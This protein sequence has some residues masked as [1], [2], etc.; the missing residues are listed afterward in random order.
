MI[1]HTMKWGGASLLLLVGALLAGGARSQSSQ[2]AGQTANQPARASTLQDLNEARAAFEKGQAFEKKQDWQAAFDAYKEATSRAPGKLEYLQRRELARSRLVQLRVDE[3]ERDAAA[4][5]IE[6]ARQQMR[7]ASRL[8]PD[9]SI[10]HERIKELRRMAPDIPLEEPMKLAKEILLQPA[11]GKF[12]FHLRSD[13]R[14]A[15]QE[16]A[17]RFGLSVSFDPDLRSR[18]VR[19][20]ADDLDF[21]SVT[22]VLEYE[23]GTFHTATTPKLFFVADDTL[24]AHRQYDAKVVRTISLP[25]SSTPDEMTE[26]LR[27]VREM[28]SLPQVDLDSASRT[29]TLRGTPR[30]VELAANIVQSIEQPPGELVLEFEILELDRNAASSIG[31]VPPQ[32]AT[33]YSLSSMEIREAQT[34]VNGL[35]A[36]LQQIFGQPSSLAGSSTGQIGNLLNAGQIGIGAL[37]PPLFAFG[38]G[39][40]TFLATLSGAAANFS[41]MLSVVRTG[42]RVLLRAQD[43]NPAT[44]FVGDRIPVP[45]NDYSSSLGTTIPGIS[46]SNFPTVDYSTGQGPEGIATGDFN[47]DGVPDLATANHT[48]NTVSV[49]LGNGDGT[50][51]TNVDY[52][53]GMGPIAVATGDFNG[54]G[55]TDLAVVNQTDNTVSI[56]LG[57]GDGTFLPKTDYPTGTSPTSI[58]VADFNGDG[59]LDLAITN[60][61]ANTVSILLGNGDGTFKPK[62]DYITA[63]GPVSVATG[64]FN[65]DGFP[66]LAIADFT[67]NA[68]SVFLGNGDGTFG[69]RADFLT[70]NGPTA[71]ASAD[72]NAD[73][74]PDLAVANGT[75]NTVSIL[76]GTGTGAFGLQTA[77]Q[78]DVDP[79]AITVDDYNIDGLPDIVT[80][81]RTAN[82]VA[83][84]LNTGGGTFSPFLP[85][86]VSSTPEG[87][88]SADFNGDGSP[89]AATANA[90]AN[91]VTII[92]NNTTFAGGAQPA[93]TAAGASPLS[94]YPG[95]TYE[96]VGLKIKATPRLHGD[97]EVSLQLK[98]E[99]KSLASKSVNGI[100]V[101]ANRSIEQTVRVKESQTS[102]LAG[103][104]DDQST[105]TLTGWPYISNIPGL[106]RF[107]SN[108]AKT[109]QDT[110]L[111]IV[112]TP[113]L[114]REAP[115][116]TRMLYAGHGATGPGGFGLFGR[117]LTPPFGPRPGGIIPPR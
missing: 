45:L 36:V 75:D 115:R 21:E 70:G 110:E 19:L 105:R 104:L 99:M 108:T 39:A 4:G 5:K 117:P 20:D 48:A 22:R 26:T 11:A 79:V 89:D 63:L 69:K 9:D 92:L 93:G 77:F 87:V 32:S 91:T 103:I 71:V 114:V 40:T 94:A 90:G 28:L 13:T 10:I 101:I 51:A 37:I 30:Q 74:I 52:P 111:M 50:F 31:I 86:P 61:T 23:T 84:L 3:A 83:V 14:S 102:I 59:F 66:D 65:S 88:V 47:G 98:I 55:F 76:L 112:V 38:G 57:A 16:V 73:G 12:S 82:D 56:F 64:D 96:D 6:D 41:N 72:F 107:L 85:L 68:V 95:V 106:G 49:L 43:G 2:T 116:Q 67:S 34:G 60:G 54:D 42:E 81:N 24:L 78:T 62:V 44:F 25:N 109:A 33:I 15:Y 7:V 46:P 80:A 18:P 113:R 8:D 35:I 97:G 53:A 29:L 27:M 1:K 17:R 58:A 100:P